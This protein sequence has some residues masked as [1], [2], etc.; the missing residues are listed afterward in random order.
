MGVSPLF[1]C[2]KNKSPIC[3]SITGL[4][5]SVASGI[6][7]FWA[8]EELLFFRDISKIFLSISFG[9]MCAILVLFIILVIFSIIKN[10]KCIKVGKIFC[11]ILLIF[12]LISFI[13]MLI[14]CIITIKDY[15]DEEK[16]YEGKF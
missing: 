11:I 3:A 12:C 2:F 16:K 6:F 10:I 14:V 7:L 13:F 8:M 1:F 9:L 15:A 4:I 5:S